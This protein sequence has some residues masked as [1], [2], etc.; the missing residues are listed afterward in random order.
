LPGGIEEYHWKTGIFDILEEYHWK[1]GIFDILAEIRTVP[2]ANM[3]GCSRT[4]ALRL[5]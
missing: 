5:L 3:L 2:P 1:T 4:D